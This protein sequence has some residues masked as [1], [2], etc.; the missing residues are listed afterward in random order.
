MK[1]IYAPVA[2]LLIGI[3]LLL[4]DNTYTMPDWANP[5]GWFNYGPATVCIVEETSVRSSVDPGQIVVLNSVKFP[6]AVTDG[7]GTFL[8][9]FDKDILDRDK[10]PPADLVQ[11]LEA[12]KSAK[13][14]ALVIK[15]G[16]HVTAIQLPNSEEKA[17]EAVQ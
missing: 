3:G 1:S 14:P 16:I 2:L 8:G 9:C 6:K 15:R 17:I 11:Y 7:G 5:I 13:L 12:A 4:S 10:K